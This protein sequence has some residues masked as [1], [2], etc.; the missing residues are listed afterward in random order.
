MSTRPNS[1]I[2]PT[3]SLKI[4]LLAH[5]VEGAGTYIRFKGLARHLALLGHEATLIAASRTPSLM[6]RR[7]EV[8]GIRL[9]LTP[10][11]LGQRIRNAGLS[12]ADA[13][14][15]LLHVRAE[16]YD[17]VIASDHRPAASLPALLARTLHG[18]TY[19]SDW[20]DLWGRGGIVGDRSFLGRALLSMPETSMERR[21]HRSADGLTAASTDLLRRALAL[22][23]PQ[24]RVIRL[25]NGVDVNLFRPVPNRE[26]VRRGIGL[27]AGVKALIYA[28]TAPIDMDLIWDS[29]RLVYARRQDTY[30]VI[31]GKHWR[32]LGRLGSAQA[33]ILQLGYLPWDEYA[34]ILGA[35][36]LMLLPYRDTSRNRGRFPGKLAFYMAV[37]RPT[38]SNPTGDIKRLFE[39]HEVGRLAGERPEAFAETILELLDH[40]RLADRLGQRARE[41]AER[42]FAWPILAQSLE[43]FIKRVR[44]PVASNHSPS[45]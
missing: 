1:A 38:I 8:D 18:A 30:L 22:G 42:D 26:A 5:N 2:T 10:G 24:S 6:T 20:A 34:A 32:G 33:N 21:I 7:L 13:M 31:L 4:L 12:P 16:R 29:F 45:N 40:E 3:R 19:I 15:R 44:N 27:N 39:E 36:D 43:A 28:G 17:V 37:G 35:G 9:H 23:I 11:I 41:I 14:Y 25:P